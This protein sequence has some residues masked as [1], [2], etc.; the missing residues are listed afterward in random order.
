MRKKRRPKRWALRHSTPSVEQRLRISNWK[1][2]CET[3]TVKVSSHRDTQQTEALSACGGKWSWLMCHWWVRPV[4]GA[5]LWASVRHSC[6]PVGWHSSVGI[7]LH[8]LNRPAFPFHFF[9]KPSHKLMKNKALILSV[10][11]PTNL[12]Q[13][14]K[15]DADVSRFSPWF[16]KQGCMLYILLHPSVL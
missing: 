11:I 1:W 10:F 7:S 13:E 14:V 8:F 12:P 6:C 5:V 4:G 9:L 2:N 3:L 16:E 15:G